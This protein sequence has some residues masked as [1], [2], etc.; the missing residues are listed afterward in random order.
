MAGEPG[1]YFQNEEL[2]VLKVLIVE[3]N[4]FI[5]LDLEAQILEMGHAVVGIAVT[6]SKAIEMSRKTFPDLALVDLQLA[7]GSRGQDAARVLRDEMRVPSI[8]VSGSLHQ[9]TE[10]EE[11]SIRPLA[12]LSKPLLSNEL[13]RVLEANQIACSAE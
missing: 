7:D 10:V 4:V 1:S 2:A 8:I 3:D 9:M 6:A 13:R 11:A 5:A 12:M